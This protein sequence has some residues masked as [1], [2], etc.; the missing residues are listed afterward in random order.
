MQQQESLGSYWE[1]RTKIGSANRDRLLLYSDR[2]RGDVQRA[3]QCGQ[4][5][6]VAFT[7]STKSGEREL[8]QDV[9]TGAKDPLLWFRTTEEEGY[10]LD[11]RFLPLLR[12]IRE[13]GLDFALDTDQM[14]LVVYWNLDTARSARERSA[15]I[16]V[17]I[18][19][20]SVPMPHEVKD[21]ARIRAR[22]RTAMDA[23]QTQSVLCLLYKG[24]DY[25]KKTNDTIVDLRYCWEHKWVI[26]KRLQFLVDLLVDDE[27]LQWGLDFDIGTPTVAAAAA[28]AASQ[29]RETS[30]SP[31]A[32]EVAARDPDATAAAATQQQREDSAALRHPTSRNKN[33]TNKYE[34]AFLY[35]NW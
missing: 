21:M 1:R 11:D 13:E 18:E 12:W 5:Q 22:I 8:Y 4:Q 28:A 23:G 31:R 19:N 3:I 10:R 9:F 14:N 15:L 16:H 32:A 33:A 27:K 20:M 34:C 25:T 2:I 6:I 24:Q 17:F 35:A 30:K 29:Q 26:H 7:L